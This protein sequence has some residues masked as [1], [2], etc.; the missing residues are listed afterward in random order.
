MED[1]E[2]IEAIEITADALSP[3]ALRGL[4]EAFVLREG[5]DYGEREFSLDEKVAQI[6]LQLARREVRV[7]YDPVSETATLVSAQSLPAA[8]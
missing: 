2:N 4:I 5:T 3:G 8:R 1:L 7:M 6:E